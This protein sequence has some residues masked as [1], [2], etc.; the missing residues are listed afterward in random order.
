MGA[1][2]HRPWPRL[3]GGSRHPAPQGPRQEVRLHDAL[4]GGR[5]QRRHGQGPPWH[6]GHRAV[7]L[8]GRGQADRGLGRAQ[9]GVPVRLRCGRRPDV[10]DLQRHP[11][12][13]DREHGV[14]RRLDR[15]HQEGQGL[16]PHGPHVPLCRTPHRPEGLRHLD[17]GGPHDPAGTRRRQVRHRR[18]RPPEGAQRGH[19]QPPRRR[20]RHLL[21]RVAEERQRAPE[22]ALPLLRRRRR[23]EP[24]RALRHCC[25]RGLGFRQTG[26]GHHQRRA[27]GLCEARGGRLPGGPRPRQRGLGLLQ[28]HGEL[29]ALPVDGHER[30]GEGDARVQ[31]GVHRAGHGAGLLLPAQ[32]SRRPTRARARRRLSAGQRP[33]ARA[34]LQHERLR[35]GCPSPA[36]PLSPEAAQAVDCIAGRRLHLDLDGH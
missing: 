34:L 12:R 30:A 11:R 9:G 7:R 1:L 19:R 35:R 22:G 36:R 17:P 27:A 26:R 31:L 23:P 15:Q 33:T 6:Q 29:R 14:V 18:R 5:P 10:R 24:Q 25:A 21:H 13:A 32:P 16:E 20:P 3:A 8:R 4:H 2:R 28:D